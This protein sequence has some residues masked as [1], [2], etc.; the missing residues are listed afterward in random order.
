[1]LFVVQK[2]DFWFVICAVM[3]MTDISLRHQPRRLRQLRVQFNLLRDRFLGLL[4]PSGHDVHAGLAQ[5]GGDLGALE[6]G[7]DLTV[8][9]VN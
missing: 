2:Y 4:G 3:H 5:L 6:D 8:E 9:L 1:M 7:V